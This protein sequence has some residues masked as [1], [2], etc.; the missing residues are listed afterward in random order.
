M[1]TFPYRSDDMN[2]IYPF[3]IEKRKTITVIGEILIDEIYNSNTGKTLIVPGGSPL[4]IAVNLKDLGIKDVRL[5]GTIGKDE[6]M[7][8]VT[9]LL[10][11]RN[12]SSNVAIKSDLKTSIVKINQTTE[13]PKA[14][15][16][17][18]ADY[19]I[20]YTSALDRAIKDSAI[21]HFSYWPLSHKVSKKT[22]LKV[23]EV[24][25]KNNTII[26]FDP[27]F[28]KD[29][30]MEGG[31]KATELENIIKNVQI[32]KPS[33]DDAKRIFGYNINEDELLKRFT[34][35]GCTLTIMSKG[36]DGLTCRYGNGTYIYPTLARNVVDATG[37][38]D[39]FY[40]GLYAAI[41]NNE[42]LDEIL[43]MG[44]ICSAHS[45]RTIGGVSKLPRYDMIRKIYSR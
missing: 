21:V 11:S 16:I 7:K 14:V 32:I 1:E 43:Y 13:T 2:N 6:Y 29:L 9:E 27:N 10:D 17:R 12:L 3:I 36:K 41:L 37:A 8:I 31:F 23:I 40:S 33:I 35:L 28:H 24:A 42:N 15:F 38:G 26:G 39:A 18:D 4:N 34:D 30:L 20:E 45:L 44:S 25:K 5:F 22:I 19:H